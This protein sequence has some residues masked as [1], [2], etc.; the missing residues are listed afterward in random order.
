MSLADR[1]LLGTRCS[2]HGNGRAGRAG[3]RH[4]YTASVWTPSANHPVVSCLGAIVVRW[5]GALSKDSVTPLRLAHEVEQLYPESKGFV[6]SAWDFCQQSGDDPTAGSESLRRAVILRADAA[7]A[8]VDWSQLVSVKRLSQAT[9]AL[10]V[11][12]FL[13]GVMSW[14]QPEIVRVGLTR[15]ACPS[16]NIEWPRNH[17]LQFVQPPALLAAGDNLVLR[18][19]DTRKGLPPAVTMH[20]RIRH[21]G[22]WQEETQIIATTKKRLEIRRPNT[23]ESLQYRATGGDHLTM[24]WQSLEVV[25]A[26]RVEQLQVTVYPPV[27]TQLPSHL[28]NKSASIY[29]GSELALQG[30][31]DQPVTQVVLLSEH[32]RQ[33]RAQVGPEGRSFWIEHSDWQVDKR[34]TYQ[35]QLTTAAGLIVRSPNELVFDVIADQPPQVRFLQP[36]NDLT[37]L[38]TV[39]VPLVIEASDE[40][41]LQHVEL[42]YAR[43]DRPNEEKQQISLWKSTA[44]STGTNTTKKQVV[45]FLWQLKPFRLTPGSVLEVHAQATDNQSATGKTL[46]SLRLHIVSEDE[47]WHQ[48]LQKQTR[49]IEKLTR[50]LREQHELQSITSDWAELPEWSMSR[51]ANVGHT[52]LFRQRQIRESLDGGQHSIVGQ[53]ANLTAAIDRN[54]LLRSDVADRLQ[55]VQSV[56]QGLHAGSLATIEQSLSEIVR[57]AQQSPERKSLLPLITTTEEQQEEVVAGLRQA[58]DLLMP[59]N[60]L[61]RLERELTALEIDQ[62]ALLQRCRK[63]LTP[64]VLFEEDKNPT[65]LADAIRQQ[66]EIARRMAELLLSMTQAAERLTEDGLLFASR[67]SETVALADDLSTQATLQS[68]AN[69][70]VR[71]R[72]GRASTLQ[73]KVLKDLAKLKA[74]LTGQDAAS[75]A[76]QLKK[77]RATEKKLQKLLRQVADIVKDSRKIYPKEKKSLAKQAE[78]IAGNLDQLRIPNA[79][80]AT[81]KAASRLRHAPSLVEKARQQLNLAQQQLIT[82]RRRQQVALARLEMARLDAKIDSLV[83]RQQTIKQEIERQIRKKA[84]EQNFVTLAAS[85]FKL[86][87]EVLAEAEQLTTLPVFAHLLKQPAETMQRVEDRLQQAKRKEPT[88]DLA[89]QAASQLMQLAKI[90]RQ[91][92]KR[93]TTKN[94]SNSDAGQGRARDKPQEQTLQLAIGQLKILRIL[95]KKLQQQTLALPQKPHLAAELARQQ[96][97]LTDLAR[98]LL[99]ETTE[100][101]STHE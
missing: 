47:L 6:S 16:S 83:I 54:Q 51:W 75:V 96:K 64:Q 11:A 39:S 17:D 24:P 57:Q 28:W 46:R 31:T 69:Q 81:R 50:L 89:K 59:G 67:L 26:P 93:F 76:E 74:R 98:Q 72:L 80:K 100:Q 35:L 32:G 70:L 65:A 8:E 15:L 27:Y 68:A 78:A 87:T 9:G 49:L 12:S 71:R 91:E 95:Q 85:Q 36:M 25:P 29:A 41:A 37:L 77:L 42:L 2:N 79:A 43:S 101:E 88:A 82:S 58:I 18:L 20:Y 45:E 60:V 62:Q 21:Q 5:R 10:A 40:L 99:T 84:N 55:A 1:H 19:H 14:W 4:K 94:S 90:L 86:R 56:L 48:I 53:L 97:Q 66:R 38:P 22:H 23:Q 34:D 13:L 61:G 92:R 44:D 63:E 33:R 73:K 7:T 3:L 30:Q 52:S